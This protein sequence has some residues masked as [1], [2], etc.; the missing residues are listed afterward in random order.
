MSMM[1]KLS[2]NPLHPIRRFATI[3]NNP[4]LLPKPPSPSTPTSIAMLAIVTVGVFLIYV[5]KNNNNDNNNNNN[6]SNDTTAYPRPTSWPLFIYSWLP[7]NVVSR[8]WGSINNFII[9]TPLRSPA[10][11]LYS[12]MFNVNLNDM[13]DQNLQN[14]QNLSQFFYRSIKK[15]VRP[16]DEN[17]ILT[18]PSDGTIL[19]FGKVSSN[20]TID[21]VKGIT[22]TLNQLLGTPESDKIIHS[23][24]QN[25]QICHPDIESNSL[26]HLTP[27]P[28]LHPHASVLTSNPS[29]PNL[30]T[31]KN[32]NTTSSNNNN[33]NKD[34][35]ESAPAPNDT[36]P[37]NDLFY[38]VIYLAPGDYH[39]FHSPTNWVTTT[40]RHFIGQL[41]SVAPYFQKTFQNLFVLNERVALLGYWKYGFFSMTP[42]GATN[43]G[44]IKLNF[45]KD[46]LTNTNRINGV[47]VKKHTCYESH[48]TNA[49]KTLKGHPLFKGDEMGGFMLGST[50]VLVFEAPKSFKFKINENEKVKMGQALGDI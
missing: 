42:V 5:K 31:L 27:I 45:D 26:K 15:S 37:E 7:L 16:I 36:I 38:T 20:A 47:K 1:K 8:I 17:S 41:Y 24:I 43:V 33:N 44:S 32:I 12:F 46:L 34:F 40:R 29:L 39:R 50:V 3:P 30:P 28:N 18:S 23:Q 19:G 11:K 21:Q 9:P 10:F 2:V 35:I 4:R 49:S 13:Q 22:Y 6:N 25:C 48:Y 14:Y